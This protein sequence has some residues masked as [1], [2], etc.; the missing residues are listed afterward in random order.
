LTLPWKSTL[1]LVEEPPLL[2]LPR[3]TPLSSFLS[4]PTFVAGLFD[5]GF[6]LTLSET[7]STCDR[8]VGII[9]V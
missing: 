5:L 9:L 7:V 1:T 3:N 2:A 6:G 8:F 4:S